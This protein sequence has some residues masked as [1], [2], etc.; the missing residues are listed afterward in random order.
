VLPSGRPVAE[1]LM[2]MARMPARSLETLILAIIEQPPRSREILAALGE[3][4]A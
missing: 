1:M 3:S 2:H 4:A